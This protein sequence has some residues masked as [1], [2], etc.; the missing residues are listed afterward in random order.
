MSHMKKNLWLSKQ[1]KNPVALG[2]N[3]KSDVHSLRPRQTCPRIVFPEQIQQGDCYA[4][5]R[6]MKLGKMILKPLQDWRQ[7]QD[8]IPFSLRLWLLICCRMLKFILDSNFYTFLKYY[9]LNFLTFPFSL[10]FWLLVC[11]H[12]LKFSLDSNVHRFFKY[13]KLNFFII[14]V[15]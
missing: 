3:G 10:S 12:M 13:C 6:C 15:L 4:I 7:G 11:C 14:T 8:Y 1:E 5:S 2:K 9:K